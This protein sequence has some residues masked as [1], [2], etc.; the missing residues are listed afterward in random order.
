MKKKHFLSSS[1]AVL[2]AA[3]AISIC[4]MGVFAVENTAPETNITPAIQTEAYSEYND[5]DFYIQAVNKKS[6]ESSNQ[7]EK[8]VNRANIILISFGIS[9]L[10]TGITIYVIYSGYKHNGRTEPY[11]YTKKAPLELTEEQDDLVDVRVTSVRIE[12]NDN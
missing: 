6:G 8:S 1:A 7:K 11:E 9:A 5:T 12:R 3:A 2:A 4:T 10:V